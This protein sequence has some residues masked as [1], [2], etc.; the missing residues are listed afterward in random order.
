MTSYLVH[1]SSKRDF[2]DKSVTLQPELFTGFRIVP[3]NQA[4][5]P[6]KA[7]D[8][9]ADTWSEFK[10]SGDLAVGALA[11]KDGPLPLQW[12]ITNG[13]TETITLMDD[14]E[15]YPFFALDAGD[16]NEDNYVTIKPKDDARKEQQWT[17]GEDGRISV[18]VNETT[19]RCL[20]FHWPGVLFAYGTL[21]TQPCSDR[22]DDPQDVNFQVWT[23]AV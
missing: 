16:L 14:L 8:M 22:P 23:T 17:F 3:L 19:K 1:A 15:S 6:Y 4:I 21:I 2:V 18:A 5:G 10:K 11:P 12:D 13:T 20:T 9:D 7:E